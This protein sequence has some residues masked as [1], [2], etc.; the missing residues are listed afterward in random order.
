MYASSVPFSWWIILSIISMIEL[1]IMKP[2]YEK[3]EEDTQKCIDDYYQKKNN[4]KR[5]L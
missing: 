2:K 5:K 4:Y 1:S 3:T